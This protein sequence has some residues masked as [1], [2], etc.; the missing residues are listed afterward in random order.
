MAVH[1]LVVD[2]NENTQQEIIEGLKP[3]G[4]TAKSVGDA[5]KASEILNNERFDLIITEIIM[6]DKDGLELIMEVT[7]Q[8]P[9]IKIIAMSGHNEGGMNY[10]EIARGLGANGAFA[11]PFTIPELLDAVKKTINQKN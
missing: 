9:G 3:A 11:K 6:P 8:F 10:L 2:E 7:S 4:Y 5:K 1:I